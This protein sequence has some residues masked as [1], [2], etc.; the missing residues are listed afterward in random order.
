MKN[1][2]KIILAGMLLIGSMKSFSQENNSRVLTMQ[3]AFELAAKYLD[4]YRLIN[5][6]QV[7]VDNIKLSK[8]RLKNILSLQKQGIVTNND[9]LR[10]KL[11][12]SDLELA[13][14]KTDDNIQILNQQLNIVL[15]LDLNERLIPD[16]SL[17]TYSFEDE[18]IKKLMA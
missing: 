12:I 18:D 4:I 7:Y 5:Q 11:I 16:S 8:E 2:H 14:R 13:V 3:D 6:R 17:L 15:G 10:T 9:V 1:L